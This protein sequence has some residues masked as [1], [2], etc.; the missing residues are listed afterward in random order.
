MGGPRCS[1]VGGCADLW[2]YPVANFSFRV[3]PRP[4]VPL[5]NPR[6]VNWCHICMGRIKHWLPSWLPQIKVS[7][8][9]LV[10]V[11]CVA[12]EGNAIVISFI[13]QHEV[14]FIPTRTV[15]KLF[16][17]LPIPDSQHLQMGN[18]LR[19]V[20]EWF[21]I[22]VRHLHST[23][24]HEHCDWYGLRLAINLWSVHTFAV[25][26]TV[27]LSG[28]HEENHG[29]VSNYF[30]DTATGKRWGVCCTVCLYYARFLVSFYSFDYFNSTQKEGVVNASLDVS[31]YK[32]DPI[33]LTNERWVKFRFFSENL[34]SLDIKVRYV[35]RRGAISIT[36]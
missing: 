19:L 34:S 15:V 6:S 31:W 21:Q 33:W 16:Q 30:Y 17:N 8:R 7:S 10:R 32:G 22:R 4:T 9:Y 23:K 29:I 13:L 25:Y 35:E 28:L 18:T 20:R 12:P 1:A 24:S 2:M 27:F 26:L 5:F 36:V 14:F 11:E 3:S